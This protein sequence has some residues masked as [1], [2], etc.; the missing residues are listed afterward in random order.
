MV[1]RRA[2]GVPHVTPSPFPVLTTGD[3][4]VPDDAP[5]R[6]SPTAAGVALAGVLL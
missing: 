4:R 6:V 5:M 1:V 3:V 2:W